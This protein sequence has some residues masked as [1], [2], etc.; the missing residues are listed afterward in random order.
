MEMLGTPRVS[1]ANGGT[2]KELEN[3]ARKAR[4]EDQVQ[5]LPTPIVRD[6]KDGQAPSMRDGKVSIDTVGR[7]VM[8][9][10][11]IDGI[12]WGKY[13]PAIMRWEEIIG[14]KAPAPTKPDGKDAAHRL[15]A[16]FVEWLMGLPEGWVC[17]PEMNLKRNDQLKALGNGVVPQQAQMALEFLLQDVVF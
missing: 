6:Y 4:L 10:G 2:Q 12:S 14:R 5:L 8:N 1:S 13:E 16:D 7:A 9:S 3:G 17:D 11:E 15:S